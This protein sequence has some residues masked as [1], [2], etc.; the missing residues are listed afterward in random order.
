MPD[1]VSMSAHR[2]LQGYAAGEFTPL[3]VVAAVQERIDEQEPTLNAFYVRESELAHDQ[4][5]ASTRRWRGGGARGLI[6]GVPLTLKENIA[7]LGTP[8]PAGSAAYAEALPAKDDGPAAVSTTVEGAVRLG[9]TVMPDLGMLSSGVSSLHGVTRNP[10][11]PAWTPGGSS[12]GAAA[13][14][15]G[16]LGPLHVGSDIGGSVRLPAG[17]TGLASLKPTFGLV[18]V[19][20]PYQGRAIGPLA[21]TIDD[22]A[23]LMQVLAREDP[24]HRDYSYLSL[25]PQAWAS[26][27]QVPLTD[28][29]VRGLRVGRQT[30]AGSGLPT[31]PEVAKHVDEV[32][33]MFARAGADVEPVQPFLP[34]ELLEQLDL[35]WRARFW[36]ALQQLPP[37]ARDQTLPYIYRWASAAA[38]LSGSAVIEAHHAVQE[39]RRVTMHATHGFDVVVSPV[40]PVAAFPAEWHGPTD[41]PDTAMAHIAYTVPYNF[42]EQPAATVN[43]GFTVDGRP[44][45][46]QLAGRRFGDVDVLRIARWYEAARP[47]TARPVWPG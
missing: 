6:D 16:R 26:V 10:W 45:G 29:S 3:E 7:T 40:A 27:W 25:P 35:F 14:G 41:D 12:A 31:D 13:A 22:V 42:S 47:A 8:S 36:S 43:A 9:K 33:N 18:P 46:V 24:L 20:P 19:D 17:W 34:P 21:R 2:L 44:V 23:L 38:D 28:D 15:A 1:L 30:D 5:T 32:A 11:N 37:P 4:A 39:I